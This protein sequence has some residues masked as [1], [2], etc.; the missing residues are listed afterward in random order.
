[1]SKPPRSDNDRP[2]DETDGFASPA[3]SMHEV[4]PAYLGY[5]SAAEIEALEKSLASLPRAEAAASLRKAL[6]RIADDALH[7]RLQQRLAALEG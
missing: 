3:C 1:M 6:P 7:A 5:L 2:D 4:D